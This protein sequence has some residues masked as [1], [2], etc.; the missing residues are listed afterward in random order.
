[1]VIGR[2]EGNSQRG[3]KRRTIRAADV[4]KL[5]GVSQTT[6]SYVLN[7][8]TNQVI[9]PETRKRVI[10]AASDLGY[11]PSGAARTL[12]RG[13][14][15]IVLLAIS[16]LR[17]GHSLGYLIEFLTTELTLLGLNLVVRRQEAGSSLTPIWRELMPLAVV[18]SSPLEDAEFKALQNAGVLLI[19][20]DQKGIVEQ[21]V[22]LGVDQ[23]KVG[24]LQANYLLSKGHRRFAYA[25]PGIPRLQ[26]LYEL[27]LSGVCTE[28]TN[29]GMEPPL[30]SVVPPDATEAA[31]AL[32]NW[33]DVAP[34][35][36]AV[37]AYNDESAFAVLAGMKILKLEAP[38]DYAVIGVDNVNFAKFA[39]PPL[40]SIEKRID[41]VAKVIAHQCATA[42]GL[43]DVSEPKP[44]HQLEVAVRQ[45]A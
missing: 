19:G 14:S 17:I 9:R 44:I 5:A 36:T 35:L 15:N 3:N 39:C 7:G 29:H 24:R 23:H 27:R 1:M 2:E 31:N 12:R 43:M 40:T 32:K 25:A 41:I 6:V 28:L 33:R 37:C 10:E 30:V 11:A 38:A 26:K 42:A 22:H 45:S 20:V 18:T 21:T 4:A 34:D 16:S 13:H 8:V